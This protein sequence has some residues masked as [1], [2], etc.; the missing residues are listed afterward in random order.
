MLGTL[1]VAGTLLSC[2][3]HALRVDVSS[4]S[5]EITLIRYDR[6][7]FPAGSVKDV[8]DLQQFADRYPE[9]TDLF[10]REVISAGDVET[11]EGCRMMHLFLT[12]SMVRESAAE[13]AR[14]F[15]DLTWLQ[16]SLTRGF[17]HYLYY[18]PGKKLPEV[19][20]C[21]SG[22]NDP[23]FTNGKL[24]GISLDQ[25]LGSD[26]PLYGMLGIPRYKQLRKVPAVIPV[27]V[28]H[29]WGMACFPVSPE[30]TT[31]LDYLIYEGKLLY[32]TEAMLP[33][34][35]DSLLTGFTSQQLKWC[36]SN[37]AE[38]W[39]YLVENKLLFSTER[40]DLI[41]YTGDGP[42]TNGFPRES[43][44]RTGVWLGRQ[45]I[46]SYMKRNPSVG[47]PALMANPSSLEVL[48]S[49]GYMPQ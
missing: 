15:Q 36:R 39:N 26:Y 20:T 25:Y 16:K 5:G 37:E 18:Y 46:R 47:L 41:R 14:Q 3:D 27:E 42:T 28:M 45:I 4:I 49:S 22:F 6:E 40:M 17:K 13:V 33:G 8:A 48:N 2:K 31:L 29:T 30:A 21:L 19:Y 24:I 1:V 23:V 38:M 10:A 12:D 35:A 9:F 34:T 32:F 11:E 44:A 43:P 7:L